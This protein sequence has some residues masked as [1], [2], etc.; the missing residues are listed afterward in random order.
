MEILRNEN[1]FFKSVVDLIPTRIYIEKEHDA[2]KPKKRPGH[3]KK[4]KD[5]FEPVTKKQKIARNSKTT[6]EII[7]TVSDEEQ[8]T[9]AADI[10]NVKN[11]SESFTISD[12]QERL[13]SKIDLMKKERHQAGN[14]S[15]VDR[16]LIRKRRKK[17][18]EKYK[19]KIKREKLQTPA[20]ER[21]GKAGQVNDENSENVLPQK[22]QIRNSEGKVVFS[23]FDFGKT[24]Q[25]KTKLPKHWKNDILTGG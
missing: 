6:S 24:K 7:T 12:L 4:E 18:R 10:K 20:A 25:S 9:A 11:E 17:E 13:K 23:K 2:P 3:S 16:D 14:R 15:E 19:L 1:D 22:N 21:Q 5:T 8:D